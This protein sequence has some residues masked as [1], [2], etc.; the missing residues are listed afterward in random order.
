MKRAF[1]FLFILF[2]ASS[3]LAQPGTAKPASVSPDPVWSEQHGAFLR[4]YDHAKVKTAR[5]LMVKATFKATALPA[6]PA[7][8]DH[9]GSTPMPMLGNDRVGDCFYASACHHDSLMT[10]GVGSPSAFDLTKVLK[11][12]NRLSGGDNG[13]SDQE[14]QGEWKNRGL[15]EVAD[16]KIFDWLYLDWNDL[17]AVDAALYHFPGSQFTFTVPQ[18]WISNSG[19]GA[20][21]DAPCPA[22]NNGHAVLFAGRDEKK[23]KKLY[24]WGTY[25]WI[26]RAGV[27][28]C[29]P[30]GFVVASERAF[31]KSGYNANKKHVTE[32]DKLWQS[33][34]GKAFPAAVIAKFP[35][36]GPTP[37]DPTPVPPGPVTKAQMILRIP[38]QPDQ[39]FDVKLP[40]SGVPAGME[41]VPEGT[42]KKLRDIIESLPKKESKLDKAVEGVRVYQQTM[43]R[44]LRQWE[45]DAFAQLLRKAQEP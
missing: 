38:G 27:K 42:S 12:Y 8:F 10:G 2:A 20:E 29:D 14:I 3:A 32:V 18:R 9:A 1:A 7:T 26:T 25:V 16:A 30:D 17:D 37:P 4:F 28:S 31:D 13:L 23:R 44:P 21:W 5:G 43:N 24:T 39:A 33:A 35:P 40:L 45:I 22:N 15:A 6:P 11:A 19:T 36:I 34:G 41:L